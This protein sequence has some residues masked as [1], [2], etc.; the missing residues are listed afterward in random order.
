MKSVMDILGP[1][2]DPALTHANGLARGLPA[3][4]YTDERFLRLEYERWLSRTW[5]LVGLAHQI[6]K[7]GDARPVPALPLLLVRDKE[8]KIRCFHNVCRHRGHEILKAPAEG[9]SALICP[10]HSWCYRLD[11]TL[12]ATPGF[13][14]PQGAGDRKDQLQSRDLVPVNCSQWHDW[15]FVNLDGTAGPLEDHLAPLTARL[16]GR[17]TGRLNNRSLDQLTPFHSLDQGYVAANW[18]LVME[19]SLEPYHTPFVHK[20]TGAGIPLDQHYMLDQGPLL[21]CGI[22]VVDP[23]SANPDQGDEKLM[24]EAKL[25]DSSQF[26][27]LPP[28]FVFMTFAERFLVVHRNLP[29]PTRPD[30]TWRSVHLYTTDGKKPD[31]AEIENWRELEY[32]IHVEEDGPVYESLQRNKASPVS[33]DGGVLSPQWE[34]AVRAFYRRLLRELDRAPETGMEGQT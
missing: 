9:L 1:D 20:Q 10:Y 12:A 4:A 24:S 26:L 22:D 18:K 21:G 14:G 16:T 11:G 25:D 17:L 19:N 31:A 32:K 2:F 5:L 6:P 29:H 33:N 8:D 13:Y 34:T 15:I 27:V 7:A 23:Q 30:R 28:L 3:A